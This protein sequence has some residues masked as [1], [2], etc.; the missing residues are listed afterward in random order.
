VGE[1]SEPFT[2]EERRLV[3]EE[4]FAKSWYDGEVV[5][6]FLKTAI[7][8]SDLGDVGPEALTRTP[9]PGGSQLYLRWK[10]VK[11]SRTCNVELS[12]EMEPWIEGFLAVPRARGRFAWNKRLK[13]IELRIR[14][15]GFTFKVNPRRFRHTAALDLKRAGLTDG[16]IAYRIGC[17]IQTLAT[18][19]SRPSGQVAA[20]LKEKGW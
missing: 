10:R 15:R 8:P 7:H 16:E 19:C 3:Y 14:K 18:Y 6:F 5:T 13:R 4:A 9:I 17:S 2:D 1:S 11:N 12:S 20:L